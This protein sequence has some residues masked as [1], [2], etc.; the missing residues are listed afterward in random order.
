MVD[1][2]A[3]ERLAAKRARIVRKLEDAALFPH[4]RKHATEVELPMIADALRKVTDGDYGI[5]DD[6]GE[7]IE[8]DRLE[9][10]PEIDTCKRCGSRRDGR[11]LR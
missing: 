5:C 10:I 3:T 4:V 9:A 8:A 1:A 6:C 7:P 11:D 2:L